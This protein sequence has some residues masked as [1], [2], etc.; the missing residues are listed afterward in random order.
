MARMSSRDIFPT[1][2]GCASLT[3]C[4]TF[5]TSSSSLPAR[6]TEPHS[7][8]ITFA[9]ELLSLSICPPPGSLNVGHEYICIPSP[10][11]NLGVILGTRIQLCGSLVATLDG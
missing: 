5:S 4:S 9:V 2:S 6:T 10:C 7:Q 8:L 3:C 11:H 1:S